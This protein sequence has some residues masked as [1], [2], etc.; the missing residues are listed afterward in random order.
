M[1]SRKMDLVL[2]SNLFGFRLDVGWRQLIVI[3]A[4]R[5]S[6]STF[7][8][9]LPNFLSTGFILRSL[10]NGCLNRCAIRVRFSSL[11]RLRIGAMPPGHWE[12]GSEQGAGRFG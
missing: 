3:A 6:W 11:L 7:S 5:Q 12:G 1:A 2:V 10:A 4:V 9:N 8:P